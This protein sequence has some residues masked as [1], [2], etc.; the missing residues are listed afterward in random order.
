[1]VMYLRAYPILWYYKKQSTM[2]RSSIEAEYRVLVNA[3]IK[4]MWIESLLHE[5]KITITCYPTIW[6]D[7]LSTITLNANPVFMLKLGMLNWT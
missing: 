6:Y 3:T 4:M 5:I 2:L 1:M 7:H